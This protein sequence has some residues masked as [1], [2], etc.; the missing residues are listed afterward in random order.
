MALS[1]QKL[2]AG[3]KRTRLSLNDKIKIL[4]YASEN[5][6][7]GCR[8]I[9]N[10]FQIGKTA[11]ATILRDGKKLRK[12]YEF[13]KGDCKTKRTGQFMVINEILYKWYGKCCAA[14]IYP[15]GSM[16]QEESLKIKESL[17]DSSLDSF[18]ASNGWLEKWKSC[19]GIRETRIT[20]E[21]DD[22]SVSTVRS[23]IERLPELVK[24]YKL[25]D[26]WNMDELGLFFKLL[27]DKGLI[28]KTK[29]EKGGKK[30]KVRLTAAF[31]VNAAGQKVDEPVII[32]KSKKP[33][34]FRNM[35]NN[36]LS[37]PLGVYYFSNKKAW[38][39]GEIMSKVLKRHDRKM[40]LQNQNVLLF[41]DNA[42]SHQESIQNLIK[43]VI[44]RVDENMRAPDI[45]KAV[46]ILKVIGWVKSAWEEVT[47]DTI[48]H[49]F[50]KCGFPT[51]DYA[52]VSSDFDEVFQTLFNEISA[53]CSVDEYL[54]A[55][56]STA[57]CEEVDANK[58]DW[59]ETLRQ[60]CVDEVVNDKEE[61]IDS[62]LD[63]EDDANESSSSDA[64]V[65][66]K[67]VLYLLDK[68]QLFA[69]YN[70]EQ[71]SL[72][73]TVADIISMVE[74]FSI[75]SKKQSSITDFFKKK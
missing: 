20:G 4:N 9:V 40:K 34:C 1:K 72:Q 69:A 3:M 67:E 63:D 7:K 42:T 73:K 36:D 17:N 48:K 46:D 5:P 43:Y 12:E 61:K 52:T 25:E 28:E 59:R 71:G 24:G 6:K 29:S 44:S 55:D 38:M 18:T 65:T 2:V 74:D 10:Q 23:W 49:C 26:V 8:E 39:N 37:R 13:F 58:V 22:V 68:V 47:P 53:D 57:T 15:F 60:E 51:E 54:D 14:G 50:E 31:F 11:A 62:D 41:L 70:D 32:W 66:V 21:A 64:T 16:L 33:R 35:K 75:H 19:Y 56:N 30:S 27:P 45:I